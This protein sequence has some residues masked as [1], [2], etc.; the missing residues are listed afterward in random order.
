MIRIHHGADD[1]AAIKAAVETLARHLPPTLQRATGNTDLALDK[2]IEIRQNQGGITVAKGEIITPHTLNFFRYLR[3]ERRREF[4]LLAGLFVAF[5]FAFILALDL[6]ELHP[7]VLSWPDVGRGHAERIS[8]AL[9]VAMLTT[10]I[11]LGFE[12][13]DWRNETTEVLWLFG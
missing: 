10:L 2:E 3:A 1:V 6:D 11:N 5:L 13:N 9:I 8:S 7:I 12:Y 4:F